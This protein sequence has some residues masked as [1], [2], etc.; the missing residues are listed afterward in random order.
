MKIWK[1]GFWVIFILSF[2]LV[3]I[4]WIFC[5]KINNFFF[6]KEEKLKCLGNFFWLPSD[7]SWAILM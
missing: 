6:F 4:C 2:I 7:H 3:C 5:N 1:I